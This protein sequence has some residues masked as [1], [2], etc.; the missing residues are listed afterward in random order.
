MQMM[1]IGQSSGNSYSTNYSH[2]GKCLRDRSLVKNSD[3]TIL[4]PRHRINNKMNTVQ[5]VTFMHIQNNILC[6]CVGVHIS[7]TIDNRSWETRYQYKRWHTCTQF[8]VCRSNHTSVTIYFH[9]Q[10]FRLA[11]KIIL[12]RPQSRIN[13]ILIFWTCS[14]RPHPTGYFNNCNCGENILCQK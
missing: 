4:I 12:A 7:L 10:Y 8:V 9:E 5:V 1:A 2:D 11:W 13:Y 14:R 6:R 3:Y